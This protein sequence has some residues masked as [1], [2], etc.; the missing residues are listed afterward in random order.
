MQKSATL[1]TL[2]L[3]ALLGFVALSGCSRGEM[4]VKQTS[5]EI[6]NGFK[7]VYGSFVGRYYKPMKDPYGFCSRLE[8]LVS[9]P[10]V[11]INGVQA[12]ISPTLPDF[13]GVT[14]NGVFNVNV[15]SDS[16][17][18]EVEVEGDTALLQ[19][20]TFVVDADGM[21]HVNMHR[22]FHYPEMARAELT[23]HTYKLDYFGYMGFGYVDIDGINTREFALSAHGG[24]TITANGVAGRMGIT[25]TGTSSLDARSMDIGTMYLNTG[26]YAHAKV[27]AD[28]ALTAVTADG[29][30]IRYYGHPD[31]VN[32]IGLNG[33]A[34]VPAVDHYYAKHG[35]PPYL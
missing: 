29:S 22:G 16:N 30:K 5:A 4:E 18:S 15:V 27:K 2:A 20:V 19:H 35:L 9:C 6:S 26:E 10:E 13:H 21:L 12:T 3:A 31:K 17:F 1:V 25:L 34:V 23:I 24:G 33:G 11:H 7:R 14:V 28:K 8:S 32:V